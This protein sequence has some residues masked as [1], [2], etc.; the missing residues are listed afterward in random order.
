MKPRLASA[1]KAV[2]PQSCYFDTNR[3]RYLKTLKTR[4]GSEVQKKTQ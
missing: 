2:L 1:E 4:D 3:R